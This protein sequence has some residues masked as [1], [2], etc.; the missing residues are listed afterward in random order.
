MF[1]FSFVLQK[2]GHDQNLP[3]GGYGHVICMGNLSGVFSQENTPE[4]Y[5]ETHKN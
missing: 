4:G 2:S 5:T 1:T 3:T